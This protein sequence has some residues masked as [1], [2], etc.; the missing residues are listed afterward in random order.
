V[1]VA[2]QNNIIL[3]IENLRT[4]FYLDEG[5]LRAVD[6]VDLQLRSGKTFGLVGES[7]CG[8][9]VTAQS[10]LRIVPPPGRTRGKIVLYRKGEKDL[11]LVELDASGEVIRS[12]RGKEITM[13]FQEPMTSFSPVHT[14]GDQIMEAIVLHRTKV[15]QE[16]RGIALDMLNKVSIPNPSQ[17]I[18]SYPHQ[19]SGGMRQRAMIAMALSCNPTLLIADE[20]TTALDV[21]VQI[22]VLE[23]MKSLQ[24]EYGMSILYITH[25]LGVIAEMCETV[26]V[27]YLG[28]VVEQAGVDDI[29][30]NPLHPY[31]EA[32][33]RSIP[34]IGKKARA[35]LEAI[36][37]SVPLPLNLPSQC[38]FVQRCSKAIE[39]LC[40]RHD[41][42]LMVV[43][44]AHRVRCFLYPQVQEALQRR[45]G[46]GGVD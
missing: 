28:E 25:N 21:T 12:I 7:G 30:H 19:L 22:Q 23:L 13:I 8:K 27:M 31:T 24:A 29:F 15:K 38:R 46:A 11:D 16:A 44:D 37:G 33:L 1:T 18:E 10:I 3:E 45:K 34:K 26:A 35:R 41:P 42:E 43:E 20:P 6:G 36:K 14:I 39:G 9:S 32:L 40:D 2:D 5:I 17:T 4:F